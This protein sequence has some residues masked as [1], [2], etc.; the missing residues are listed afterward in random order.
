[1][2]LALPD[3]APTHIIEVTARLPDTTGIEVERAISGTI[4][5]VPDFAV[6]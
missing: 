2:R 6:H 1:V 4:H 5:R 3:L